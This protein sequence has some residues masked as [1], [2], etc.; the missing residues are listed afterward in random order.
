MK[1]TRLRPPTAWNRRSWLTPAGGIRDQTGRANGSGAESGAGPVHRLLGFAPALRT[2]V[3]SKLMMPGRAVDQAPQGG[4]PEGVSGFP[5]GMLTTHADVLNPDLLAF[6]K[7]WR[8]LDGRTPLSD[9][10]H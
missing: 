3:Q 8:Y 9:S 6:I 5:H 1:Q 7:N 10:G 2:L 4:D